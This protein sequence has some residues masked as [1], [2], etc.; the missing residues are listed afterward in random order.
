MAATPNLKIF[1]PK[2]EYV[3]CCKFAEDAAAIIALYGNGATIRNGHSKKFTVWHE[4]KEEH[5]AGESYDIV[6]AVVNHRI[7]NS[8]A[9]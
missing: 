1:N 2:G 9:E 4:G 8:W 3:A 5:L 6:A 7:K